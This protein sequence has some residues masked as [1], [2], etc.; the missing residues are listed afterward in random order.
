MGH[1]RRHV[2]NSL[3]ILLL[4][5]CTG[6]GGGQSSVAPPPPSPDF[7]VAVSPATVTVSDG[8][9]SSPVDVSITAENGFSGP[10]QI[11]VNNLPSGIT[12]NPSS[13]FSVTPGAT[14]AISFGAISTAATGSFTLTAQAVSGSLSH[15][16][17]LTL[18]VNAS[19]NPTLSRTVYLRT[20]SV[21]TLEDPANEPRHRHIAYEAANKHVFIA[22]RAMNRV[23]VFS[24]IEQTHVAQISVPAATSA[25]IAADGSTIWIGTLTEQVIAIDPATLQ[26][27]SRTA[28]PPLSPIPNAVFSRPEELLPLASGKIIVRLRQPAAPQSLLALWDPVT[29]ILTNL[30][31]IEPA[32][33]QNGL[34]AMARTGDHA[35]L[36]VAAND[37]SGE[38]AVFDSNG[39]AIVGPHGLGAGTIPLLA[40][41][42][43]GGRFAVAFISAGA[44]QLLLL[45]SALNQAA[46]PISLDIHSLSFSR[47]GSLL[48]ATHNS[49][50]PPSVEVFDANTLHSFGQVPDT[51]IQRVHTEIEEADDTHL[52][53][54]L[55]NRGI[56]FVDAAK[57][58]AL[59][60]ST[61]VFAAAP[62]AQPSEGPF[63]GGTT[64]SLSGQNFESTV[65]LK[66]GQQIA[67][68]VTVSSATQIQSSS[69]ASAAVGPVNLT[70]Y[71]PSGWLALAPDAFSYG[72]QILKIFPNAGSKNGGDTV[73]IYGYG[74]GSDASAITLKIGA[75]N[76][77]V[78]KLENVTAIA[79]SLAL[80][81]TYPFPLERI[82]L[83]T[84]AGT[85][86]AADISITSPAGTTT[87][88]NA[89]QYLQNTQVFA[90]AA[91]YKFLLYDQKRQWLYLSSTDHV[92]IFDLAASQ[93]HSTPLTPPGGPPPNAGLRGLALTPDASQLIVADFGAQNLYL[94]N[95]DTSSGS[96]VFV[97]GVPGFL[98]SGP[99]R[100]AA[101]SIQTVFVSLSGEGGTS[102]ACSGCL[103][104]LNLTASPPTIQPAPQPQVTSLTG[105][106]LV[107]ASAAGDR[108]FVAFDVIPG[109]PVG[110]WTASSPNQFTTSLSTESAT[111]LAIASDGSFFAT[112]ANATT[113]VRGAD[114][115]LAAWPTAPELEQIPG[116]VD[117]PGTA[118]HPTGA[119]L[120][121]PFLTGPP[122][123]A[124]P[125]TGIRGG[126]DILDAHSGA[127][128][129]RLFLPEPFATLST[130]TDGLHG[131]FLTVD[132]N[133]QRMFAL[134]TSGLTVVQLATVPLGF[135]SITP[136][137]ASAAGGAM[138]TI[139]GSGFRPTTQVAIGGKSAQVAFKDQ[140]TLTAVMPA[141]A[142]GPKQLLLTNPSG[143]S[144]TFDAALTA[145]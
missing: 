2:P 34:G 127:L 87:A 121:Q 144:V 7:T 19:T 130:D 143:E 107:Q 137:T 32:L 10:V 93:F 117:V 12:S 45:D 131:A 28:I 132:E 122:P 124:P 96:S 136:A 46:A 128:R 58:L 67:T 71:F 82:T 81:A 6:C 29:N 62:I 91:L 99:A 40:A 110:S 106:P 98:N 70:A 30:T 18:T 72:T 27:K 51:A 120:Y 38:L 113:E 44:T 54:A 139:R 125:V 59:P 13:P 86:G 115:T 126:I 60:S 97:G 112:R 8:A 42:L 68:N 142:P 104:Q 47:D 24:T 23:E 105:S 5:A 101:T 39:N 141:T 90:K 41:N 116:R 103:A 73:Q 52:L 33:F 35:K 100:V 66:F 49:S 89:F 64:I 118:L 79:P 78:Q 16:A 119:L 1:S 9:T 88:S 69:P 31:S 111:D 14:I 65:E 56:S 4:T 140:N 133:G 145:N 50:G 63:T 57:P 135:G 11:S 80:D 37:S 134:T 94:L 15:S 36:L 102:G 138:L 55:A 85:P 22:N 53:F 20:D 108:V 123:S 74:F 61:P 43:D 83:Q 25:D 95:P 17:T 75:I 48:Y 77:T 26:V 3:L 109:G 84:P 114:L 92:D 129:L 21:P 76:A